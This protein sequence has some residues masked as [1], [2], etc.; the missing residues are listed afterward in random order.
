MT[1]KKK[2]TSIQQRKEEV[3]RLFKESGKKHLFITGKKGAGKSTLF[4]EI[5]KNKVNY[6]GIVTRFVFE[7]SDSTE[8]LLL[9]DVMDRNNNT[10]IGKKNKLFNKM[11]PNIEGF[12]NLGA[13]ILKKYRN[14]TVDLVVF[15][16]IGF[17]EAEA[18]KYRKEIFNCFQEKKV[19]A[20]IRKESNEFLDNIKSIENTLIIDLDNMP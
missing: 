4:R 11:I 15:D 7:E 18:P 1:N 20:I 6:G 9:E 3:I 2:G 13:K 17:I 12:E 5:L 14:S 19:F 10:I 8:Y 16:E